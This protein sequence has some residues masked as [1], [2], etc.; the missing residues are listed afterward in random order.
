VP[1]KVTVSEQTKPGE[2]WVGGEREYMARVT[3][4]G[5]P[6]HDGALG[7]FDTKAEKAGKKARDEYK[8]THKDRR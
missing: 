3:Y 2:P 7:P 4:A 8:K 6:I 5:Y 1:Y